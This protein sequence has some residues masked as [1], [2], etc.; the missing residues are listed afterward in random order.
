MG[1]TMRRCVQ[2]TCLLAAI[3]LISLGLAWCA[4]EGWLPLSALPTLRVIFLASSAL[5]G[6]IGF[7]ATALLEKHGRKASALAIGTVALVAFLPALAACMR[8]A[9]PND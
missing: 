4:K 1:S 9:F 7:V 3:V 2:L 8:L 6:P 5:A